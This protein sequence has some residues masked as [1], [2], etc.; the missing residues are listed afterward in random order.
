MKLDAVV[1]KWT[2]NACIQYLWKILCYR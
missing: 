1:H 2:H